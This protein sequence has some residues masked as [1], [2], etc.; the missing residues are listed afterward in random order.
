MK[1][2]KFLVVSV[3]FLTGCNFR[4]HYSPPPINLPVEWKAEENLQNRG[5]VTCNQ[6][7]SCD[8]D[9]WWELFGDDSLNELES[10][11]VQNNPSLSSAMDVL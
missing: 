11:A 6:E 4:P 9:Y 2:N 7:T 8:I 10:K 3:I 5:E 1:I